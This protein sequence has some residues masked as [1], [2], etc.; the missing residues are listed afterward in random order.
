M[1]NFYMLALLGLFA[2]NVQAQ[3]EVT[4]QVD[5]NEQVVSADGVH[6]A[7]EF[8]G[9]DPTATPLSDDDM[10]GIWSVSLDLPTGIHEYKFINGMGWDFAEDVPPTCQ[11]E[12]AGNDNRFISIAEDQEEASSLVCFESC[13][14]CGMSTIRMRVDMSVEGSVSPNGVHVAGNFQGWDP[15]SSSLSDANGDGVWEAMV[16]FYADSLEEGQLV[17]K[18]IN[19]NAW[20]NPS[21]NLSGADCADDFGNRIHPLSELN[22]VLFGDS[23]TGA[24]PCYD[25][26]G[27][28]VS[29]TSVTFRVD[30]TSQETVSVNG[31]HIAGSFQGWSPSANAL[32]DDDGDGIWEAVLPVASGD[33]QFKFINGNDWSGNG[34]G[35]VDNELVIG[36]CAADGTDNRFLAVGSENLLYEVCYNSCEAIC[37]ENPDAADVTFRVDMS[38]EEVDA[39]GVWVI[40]NFTDPNWQMGGLQ[41]SDD[42]ANGVYEVTANISGASTVLYKFVNGDP[43]SG[44]QGVDYVEESGV[45]L[46]ENNEEIASFETDGCGLPNGFG[47]Y[48]RIHERTGTPEILE[49]VCFNKCSSCIVNVDELTTAVFKAF[50]N[51]FRNQLTLITNTRS[52]ASTVIVTDLFGRTMYSSIFE[53]GQSKHIIQTTEWSSGTYFLSTESGGGM[54]SEMFIKY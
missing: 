29:P 26:C 12:V 39:G 11:V 54:M 53:V 23:A 19:G 37:I 25:N 34:D 5:M 13:A 3:V 28:C 30:M 16:S 27:T 21:E 31:V 8:Q 44:D 17:Y 4:L 1:R 33:I 47:A 24:A 7:G 52:M 48:N 51:P 49:S 20:T 2:M 32:N 22:L 18:F 40:G 35:N 41:L 9:W 46:D 43:S 15:E 6:V 36:D 50:P 42:D 10:D 14:A 45:Q 38:E